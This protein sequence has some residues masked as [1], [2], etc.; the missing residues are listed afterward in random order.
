MKTPNNEEDGSYSIDAAFMPIQNANHSV[1]F[2][3]NEN[4]KQEIFFL[5][6]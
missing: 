3:R 2:Y 4:K 1:H 6:I 5:K